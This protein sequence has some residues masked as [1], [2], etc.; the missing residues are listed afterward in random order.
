MRGR[1]V[2][3]FGAS[4]LG[5]CTVGPDFHAPRWAS[6]G[7]WFSAPGRHVSVVSSQ[8]VAAPID[9]AWWAIFRDPELTRLENRVAASN[10][11][12]RAAFE[13]VSQSRAALGV[14]GSAAY[15]AFNANGSY[16]REKPS[17]RGIFSALRPGST[18]GSV[19]T[20]ANGAPGN[21]AGGVQTPADLPAFDIFQY[22]FD[23]SWEPDIWGRVRRSVESGRAS[24]EA[25]EWARRS[26]LVSALAELARDYVTLR[27]TQE[28]L[29]I[30]RDN[31]GAAEQA[32]GLTRQRAQAGVSTDLD[33]ANAAAQVRIV[34]A[35]IPSLEAQERAL[36]NALGLLLAQPP[37]A[38]AAEL[39]RPKP[40]PPVPPR[41]PVGVPSELLRR[42]PDIRQAEA[43]L[44]AAT[45]DVGVATADFYPSITLSASVGLQA[46]QFANLFKF[47]ARQYAAGPG[48]TIPIFQGGRLRYTLQLREATQREAAIDFQRTL[49]TAWTEVDNALTA[50]ADEQ[51]RRGELAEAVVQ[52]R[53]ALGLA[54]SRYEQGVADFLQVL[55]AERSLLNAE[56]QLASSTTSVSTDLVALYKALGGG[57]RYAEGNTKS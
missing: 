54:R 18:P 11:D 10:L 26:A 23:A 46:L 48:I 32:L 5:G 21:A 47:D 42:R 12:V 6:P 53:R 39:D 55:D 15:P 38:L 40:V 29:R 49:L 19:G 13:R 2:A 8:P 37:G 44:H 20:G 28:Q 51:R 30:A 34:A 56:Q 17:D 57:W 16:Q 41:V 36:A 33:V 9:A 35:Q 24:V 25:A 14:T 1:L 22:G 50:F 31:V 27:G 52:D 3:A 43:Q 45:A 7:S 4:L